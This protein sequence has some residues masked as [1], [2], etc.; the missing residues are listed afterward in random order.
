M[1]HLS[2]GAHEDPARKSRR[3]RGRQRHR[4]RD[5]QGRRPHGPG[6]GTFES[7][8]VRGIRGATTATANTQEAITEATEELLTELTVQNDRDIAEVSFASFPPPHAP[9]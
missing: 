8:P 7:M 5:R 6:Q 3:G 9:T 2:P 1:R 4:L